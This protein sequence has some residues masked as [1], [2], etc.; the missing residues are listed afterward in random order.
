[1]THS[2]PQMCL[3]FYVQLSALLLSVAAVSSLCICIV[4]ILYGTL[5]HMGF[6][7]KLWVEWVA[8][9]FCGSRHLAMSAWHA[10]LWFI[11][12]QVS[13]YVLLWSSECVYYLFRVFWQCAPYKHIVS[14]I[15][16][17]LLIPSTS[18]IS[19]M[20]LRIVCGFCMAYSTNTSTCKTQYHASFG[21][22]FSLV[23][24]N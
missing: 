19:D 18:C 11:A 23:V 21:T 7:T 1:M 4:C 13:G 15:C 22:H 16:A 8:T 14:S 6:I 17:C 2:H 12:E 3:I 10:V 9:V 20:P 24:W 5:W